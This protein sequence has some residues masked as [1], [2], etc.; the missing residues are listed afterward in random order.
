MSLERR[1]LVVRTDYLGPLYSDG[2]E[3][4]F[5]EIS[6]GGNGDYLLEINDIAGKQFVHGIRFNTPFGGGYAT[7]ITDGLFM[8]MDKFQKRV[9]KAYGG[10]P[11]F[12]SI[13]SFFPT[14]ATVGGENDEFTLKIEDIEGMEDAEQY[15]HPRMDVVVNKDESVSV[16]LKS[17]EEDLEEPLEEDLQTAEKLEVTFKKSEQPLVYEAFVNVANRVLAAL[18]RGIRPQKI[19]RN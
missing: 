2:H 14:K 1:E 3:N 15:Y 19:T 7:F 12:D 13:P 8:L 11:E 4:T 16:V 5:M 9:G 17:N 18:E 6:R 10:D